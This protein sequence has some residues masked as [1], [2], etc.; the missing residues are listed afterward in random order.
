LIGGFSVQNVFGHNPEFEVSTSEDILKFCEFFYEEYELLEVDSL[1]EQHP[2]FP[3]LRA[4][5]ILYNHVAWNSTHQARDVVLIAEIEKY[6]GDSRY[7]KE[8]HI[9]YSNI[10]PDWVKKEAI[11]WANNES[12]D[13]VFAYAIRTLLEAG[14]LTLNF[15]ERSC[16]ENNLCFKEGDFIKYTHFDKYGDAVTIK[17]IVESINDDD[18]TKLKAFFEFVSKASIRKEFDESLGPINYIAARR[19][20]AVLVSFPFPVTQI[21]LLISAE[22]TVNIESLAKKVIQM[23]TDVI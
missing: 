9:D 10:I 18:E 16:N 23:F 12:Q 2:N 1:I 17:H 22:P 20:K 8:R 21:L 19:D 14:V 13:M 11:L 7:I 6:L 5:V 15:S 4:C 3:N